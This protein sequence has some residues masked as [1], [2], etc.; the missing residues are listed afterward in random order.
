MSCKTVKT[1]VLDFHF[2]PQFQDENTR[3]AQKQLLFKFVILFHFNRIML[4]QSLSSFLG[5]FS[6][7]TLSS[8]TGWRSERS[9]VTF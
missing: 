6:S 7:S 5:S 8:T 4:S 2:F 9:Q 3:D 1:I